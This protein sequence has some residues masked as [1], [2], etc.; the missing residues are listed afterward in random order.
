M[1]TQQTANDL[2]VAARVV[3]LSGKADGSFMD[4]RGRVC[5]AGA[6]GLATGYGTAGLRDLATE[7]LVAYG[8]VWLYTTRGS[9][10]STRVRWNDALEVVAPMLPVD[11][12]DHCDAKDD[13]YLEGDAW[14]RVF[15]YN[16]HI[17]G[18]GAELVE[19]LTQAAEKVEAGL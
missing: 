10:P 1:P 8:G 5:L 16:D 13:P 7:D 17:C 15:H 4:H 6:V 12:G 11:C 9:A 18:G 14:Q 2:R 3:E 19:V